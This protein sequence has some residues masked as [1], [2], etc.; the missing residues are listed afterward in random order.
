[1]P[2]NAAS[3]WRTAS[4]V[5][6]RLP[7]SSA[8]NE[9]D[10]CNDERYS[11]EQEDADPQLVT[12]T[13]LARLLNQYLRRCW[14]WGFTMSGDRHHGSCPAIIAATSSCRSTPSST[15]IGGG[16]TSNRGVPNGLKSAEDAG[17]R[18]TS[19]T[20]SHPSPNGGLFA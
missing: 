16:P 13:P 5:Q 1:M 7:P 9:E 15:Q 8:A 4:A 10:A 6:R 18:L 3:R 19:R 14:C 12:A 20:A 17:R 11:Q 2:A